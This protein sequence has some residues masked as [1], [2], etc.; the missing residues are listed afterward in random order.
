MVRGTNELADF[1]LSFVAAAAVAAALAAA[2]DPR[3][4]GSAL[5]VAGVLFEIGKDFGLLLLDT[6]HAWLISAA[7]AALHD[8]VV[9][10]VR[11]VLSYSANLNN[12]QFLLCCYVVILATHA[13]VQVGCRFSGFLPGVASVNVWGIAAI[14]GIVLALV[15]TRTGLMNAAVV[16]PSQ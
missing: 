9:P 8:K 11:L 13:V 14:A 15:G 2:C 5:G 1:R 6:S 16:P 7:H 4:G 3:I 10:C 12:L